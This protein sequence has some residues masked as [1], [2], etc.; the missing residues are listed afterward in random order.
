MRAQL[1]LS[2]AI[3]L[4]A[5]VCRI[6]AV[7][8]SP[9]WDE[10]LL[11]TTPCYMP[12]EIDQQKPAV[13]TCGSGSLVVW[14]HTLEHV[15]IFASRVSQ[16]GIVQDT[17]GFP[18]SA[19][20]STQRCPAIAYDGT[21]YL[22]VW[23]DYRRGDTPDVYAARVSPSG[24]VID[25]SG[26]AVSLAPGF[27]Q[28][29]ALAFGGQYFLAVWQ[30][31]RNG[32]SS[33]VYGARLD[34]SGNVLDP[35]G[36]VISSAAT[37]QWYPAVAF[38]GSNFLVVWQ[39]KRQ[40]NYYDIYGTR[41]SQDGMVLDPEGIHISRA[42]NSQRRPALCFNG[43]NYVVVWQDRRNGP[44]NDIYF[45]RVDRSG[46]VLDSAGLPVCVWG[47]NQERPA[48][49]Y[50]GTNCLI[51][52]QDFRSGDSADVY[53]ARIDRFGNV[54]DPG[55]FAVAAMGDTQLAPAVVFNGQDYLC[56]W[57]DRRSRT[58]Y[59]DCFTRVTMAGEVLNPAGTPVLLAANA[60]H[61]PAVADWDRDGKKDLMLGTEA[62]YINLYMNQGTDAEPAF[63]TYT[64]VSAGGSPIYLNR[65]N[66]YVVDLDQDGKR[67][68]VCGANDGYVRFYRNTGS[69][70]NPTLAAEVLLTNLSSTPIMPSGTAYGS[71][72]GFC[73]WNNDGY[74]DFLISGYDGLVE[75][76]LGVPLTGTQERSA[77]IPRAGLL[78]SPTIGRTFRFECS[79][80]RDPT[81]L[82][83]FDASG[84]LVRDLS[85]G[86]GNSLTWNADCPPGLYLCR[87]A[88]GEQVLTQRL[89]V[90][91]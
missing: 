84:R 15:D 34:R 61:E 86:S 79:A 40:G 58:V 71:R 73:D 19:A 26:I 8:V 69:D 56:V 45:A 51:V 87:F 52:W 90:T 57:Q 75:L 41:V 33:D 6:P 20:L 35:S 76:W 67:D 74:L 9:V 53:G 36:I 5:L 2:C 12:A 3:F 24:Q 72:L 4:L 42:A 31:Y 18:V 16:D 81:R 60:Q 91:K 39:D 62:G 32:D 21:N 64:N 7:P 70:T 50:D 13:A 10:F 47:N 37:S 65:V 11:D 68:L 49:A 23:H 85:L 28:Y 14:E 82:S 30:D 27:Q 44:D 83:I 43:E 38:D 46:Q 55:G 77:R 63:Q 17:F 59:Q 22:A 66:P 78:V 1:K 54:L 48:I 25:S 88:S 29:P 80:P 89:V